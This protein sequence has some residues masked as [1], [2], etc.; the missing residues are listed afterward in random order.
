MAEK[1][2]EELHTSSMTESVVNVELIDA[3]KKYAPT[4][5]LAILFVLV[6]Y[7]FVSRFGE[8]KAARLNLGWNELESLDLPA[9]L[10]DTA[11]EY[12]DIGSIAELAWLKAAQIH[13]NS[14]R[15]DLPRKPAVVEPEAAGS[16]EDDAADAADGLPVLNP[17]SPDANAA[18]GMTPEERADV[19]EA[20]GALYSK[21]LTR[22]RANPDKLILE[23]QALFGKA[24]VAEMRNELDDADVWYTKVEARAG[25]RFPLW[26]SV[27]KARRGNVGQVQSLKF[28][29]TLAEVTRAQTPPAPLIQPGDEVLSDEGVSPV[30]DITP[31]S[32]APSDG[33]AG[34]DAEDPKSDDGEPPPARED[35]GQGRPENGGGGER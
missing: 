22:T 30:G 15:R 7:V 10:S 9:S 26:A 23:I 11:K 35:P 33:P 2:L 8:A 29:P 25:D 1:R 18:A 4:V 24:A 17:F 28:L 27:A 34:D 12:E 3:L 32:G 16:D 31:D 21:V 20:M 5:I 14:L 19:L 13:Y 6:A